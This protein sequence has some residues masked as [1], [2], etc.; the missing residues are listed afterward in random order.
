MKKSTL[1]Q[2][3]TAAF[4]TFD[5]DFADLKER[6]IN[7]GLIIEKQ[8]D[9]LFKQVQLQ[10]ADDATKSRSLLKGISDDN[11]ALIREQRLGMLFQA[12][13]KYRHEYESTQRWERSKG[14]SKWLFSSKEYIRWKRGSP[15]PLKPYLFI[16]GKLGCGK[17]V[18]LANIVDDLYLSK[19][20]VELSSPCVAYFFCRSDNS[21]T[22]QSRTMV[23]AFAT[24]I[25]SHPA[26]STSLDAYADSIIPALI[27]SLDTQGIGQLLLNVVR[28]NSPPIY[29]V[30]DG[31]DEVQ[32]I[33]IKKLESFFSTLLSSRDIRVCVASRT[34]KLWKGLDKNKDDSDRCSSEVVKFNHAEEIREYI[35]IEMERR[36]LLRPEA[37]ITPALYEAV[38]KVLLQ[39][40][41]GM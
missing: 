25:L 1:A 10:E 36:A 21:L 7:F 17:T 37:P 30:C 39:Y 19:K 29:F 24:Q 12:L 14:T 38:Q 31:L 33:E 11:K 26:L 13:C 40:A 3:T 23:G 2:L 32:D 27:N 18:L 34:G 41:D 9:V 8:A 22:L 4:G 5:S 35:I 6:L 15:G 28:N 20:P 16:Q